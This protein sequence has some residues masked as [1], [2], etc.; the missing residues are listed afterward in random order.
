T[1]PSPAGSTSASL[2]GVSCVTA[3]F[4]EAV[5]S[6]SDNSGDTLD[7]AASWNGQSWALQS[8]PP[9]A[10]VPFASLNAVSC[11]AVTAC[12]AGGD[13]SFT[14]SQTQYVPVAEHWNGA[15]WSPQH[16][17]AAPGATS[18]ALTG[19]SC[20]SAAFCEAVGSRQDHLG[21]T[22]IA[23]AEVWNGVR[24]KIQ[25]TANPAQASGGL[26]MS[27]S[28][29]A[30]A[31]AS[32][33]E[34]VGSSA[35]TA[36]GGAERWNG[37]TWVLQAAP[38]GPLTSVSCPSAKFCM[39]AGGDGHVEIWNGSSWSSKSSAAGFISLRSVSC[40]SPTACEAIGSGPSGDQAERWNGRSWSPQ[41]TP[42]PTGGSSLGLTAVSCAR[43]TSCEAVGSYS[44]SAFQQVPLAEVWNGSAW[45]LQHAP[46][47]GSSAF[48]SA[49][50]N[51]VWCTSPTLC[52]AVGQFS[53]ALNFTLAEVWNGSTWSLR[54]TPSYL[55]AGQNTLSAVSCTA[56]PVCRAVGVTDD[57]GQIPA[58]LIETGN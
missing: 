21:L 58:T 49:A 26:R 32:F 43:L 23:L 42:T 11:A 45:K 56:G 51:A 54:S 19:V 3:A 57:L 52:T 37:K 41:V 15:S 8:T 44:N 33:C 16:A 27:L 6:Y 40:L 55:Y 31:S 22:T 10:G 9:L 30:C 5:G 28:G 34:A 4:C 18:N 29:V 14:T 53:N 35:S 50:L 25:P 2:R 46:N 7:V 1:I 20:V 36:G 17:A 38:G 47:P 12:E 13:F 39:A 48:S 24:W